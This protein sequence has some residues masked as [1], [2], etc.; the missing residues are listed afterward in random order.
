MP[1]SSNIIVLIGLAAGISLI[2]MAATAVQLLTG[3]SGWIDTLWTFAVGA[4][5]I[6][7]ALLPAEGANDLRRLC[8]GV[9]VAVWA[10][11]LGLHIA[12]RTHEGEDDPRYAAIKA[13][14]PKDWPVYL[15]GM[16]QAQAIAAFV[17]VMAV[18][19]AA[20]SPAPFPA[21]T[22][23]IGIVILLIAF[24][25]EG[26]ADAQLRAFGKTHKKAVANIGLWRW[27]RHPNYFFEWL[28]WCG[29]AVIALSGPFGW[30]A[31]LAPVQMYILLVYVS[32][33]PPL[34]K[35]MRETRGQAFDDYAAR[36]SAFFPLPP[37]SRS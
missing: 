9:L 17:L 33:I 13:D 21:V 24:I 15:F 16:L 20:I 35:H 34:E 10:L 36:T 12:A 30:L 23:L 14:H 32:G 37:K 3:K 31:M 26:V 6:A 19:F 4:G 18:R 27:S 7:A 2:M 11:R 22:D 25:G 8:L 29:W 1:L 5:G 28:G